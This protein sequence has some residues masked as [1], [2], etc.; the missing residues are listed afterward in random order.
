VTRFPVPSIPFEAAWIQFFG[1]DCA[2][3]FDGSNPVIDDTGKTLSNR[4]SLVVSAQDFRFARFIS[5]GTTKIHV[6][7]QI[8]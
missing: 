1:D 4:T 2:V 7:F 6:D 8:S 5:T 3:T